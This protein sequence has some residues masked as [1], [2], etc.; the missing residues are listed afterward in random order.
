MEKAP[1][2]YLLK[3]SNLFAFINYFPV[4]PPGK[5]PFGQQDKVWLSFTFNALCLLVGS[6]PELQGHL[7]TLFKVPFLFTEISEALIIISTGSQGRSHFWRKSS[8]WRW[9][10][11]SN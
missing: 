4:F 5:R 10:H 7:C 6:Q 1:F 11:K 8:Y 2:Y 9:L 3:A